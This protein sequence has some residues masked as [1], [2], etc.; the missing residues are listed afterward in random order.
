MTLLQFYQVCQKS[1]KKKKNN[2]TIVGRRLFLLEV[3]S[4][5]VGVSF[6]GVTVVLMGP[7]FQMDNMI[8]KKISNLSKITCYSVLI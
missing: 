7:Q 8:L 2:S 5:F 1:R 3:F 6:F 4:F